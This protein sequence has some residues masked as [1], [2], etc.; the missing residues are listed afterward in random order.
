MY[1]YIFF[2]IIFL[3][4][5]IINFVNSTNF[6]IIKI[7][8]TLIS[9]IYILI[10]RIKSNKVNFYLTLSL[11]FSFLA[12][13]FFILIKKSVLGISSFII[14]QI[15]YFFFIKDKS[16]KILLLSIINFII[17]LILD[18]K[19]LI[20][21]AILYGL[22]VIINIF[23][24]IKKIRLKRISILFLVAIL[25]LLVCDINIVIIRKFDLSTNLKIICHCIE[26]TFY[27]ANLTLISLLSNNS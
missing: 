6:D 4:I 24:T 9:I 21:E 15:F 19:I 2:Q 8:P 23:L 13:I 5:I 17:C 16:N 11:I 27:I 12:D 7:F 26:W 18:K 1:L 3:I 22:I 14:V 10:N 20:V 25:C